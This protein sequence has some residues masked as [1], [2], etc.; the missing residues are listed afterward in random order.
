M[1]VPELGGDSIAPSTYVPL[2]E[3][4]L[5]ILCYIHHTVHKCLPWGMQKMCYDCYKTCC[6]TVCTYKVSVFFTLRVLSKNTLSLFSIACSGSISL[7]VM[8]Y[9]CELYEFL[10]L[11]FVAC[12]HAYHARPSERTFHMPRAHESIVNMTE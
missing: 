12:S 11:S 1:L 4:L 7:E 9:V 8:V 6:N 5:S 10:A 3:K 2:L